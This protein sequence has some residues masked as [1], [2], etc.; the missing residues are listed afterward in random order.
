MSKQISTEILTGSINP[1]TNTIATHDTISAWFCITNS[2]LK[3]GGFLLDDFLAIPGLIAITNY[4]LFFTDYYSWSVWIFA[5]VGVW[6]GVVL[7]FGRWMEKRE[8]KKQQKINRNEK[9]KTIKTNIIIYGWF[10]AQTS[11][12][13]NFVFGRIELKCDWISINDELNG[14]S[15]L[16]LCT[17]RKM[18]SNDTN[19]SK[20]INGSAW[21]DN[22]NKNKNKRWNCEGEKFWKLLLYGTKFEQLIGRRLF[23]IPKHQNA[24]VL[25]YNTTKI[26]VLLLLIFFLS[27]RSFRLW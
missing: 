6:V 18:N 20:L 13:H 26:T 4:F 24:Y 19:G 25:I 1:T 7:V 5:F 3:N 16:I 17:D 11:F 15:T 22:E 23:K 12:T 27:L 2:W 14:L 8:R 9:R 21:N 10:T